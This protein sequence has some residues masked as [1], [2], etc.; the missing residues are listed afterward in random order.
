MSSVG[1]RHAVALEVTLRT[2]RAAGA[3]KGLPRMLGGS[4][5]TD[6]DSHLHQRQPTTMPPVVRIER[7]APARQTDAY[8]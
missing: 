3:P 2:L 8:V 1:Q 7:V 5:P 6:L 4:D